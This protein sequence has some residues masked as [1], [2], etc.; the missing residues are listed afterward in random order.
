MPS[1][2][3]SAFTISKVKALASRLVSGWTKEGC[4]IHREVRYSQEEG[5]SFVSKENIRLLHHPSNVDQTRRNDIRQAHCRENRFL[6]NVHTVDKC[7]FTNRGF[8]SKIS[9]TWR[10]PSASSA[11]RGV[12]RVTTPKFLSAVVHFLAVSSFHPCKNER[13]PIG[14][15]KLPDQT[16]WFGHSSTRLD[17]CVLS[18]IPTPIASVVVW[19]VAF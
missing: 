2:W 7:I 5:K 9:Q 14:T 6:Y 19:V 10:D 3:A 16:N 1:V 15:L 17:T 18:H 13:H 8:S 4:C 11:I 12:L